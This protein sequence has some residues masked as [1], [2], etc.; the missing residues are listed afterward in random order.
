MKRI[1]LLD[2]KRISSAT[3]VGFLHRA[4]KMRGVCAGCTKMIE[5][6]QEYIALNDFD[7]YLIHKDC[8]SDECVGEDIIGVGTKNIVQYGIKRRAVIC[9]R[10]KHLQRDVAAHSKMSPI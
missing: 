6:S 5:K 1:Y 2:G 9:K 3:V 10:L 8:F 4:R 7:P